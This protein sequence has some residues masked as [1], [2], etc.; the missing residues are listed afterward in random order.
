MKHLLEEVLC[1]CG[2]KITGRALALMG[3][4]CPM[5]GLDLWEAAHLKPK[6]KEE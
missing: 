3:W 5:C 2:V 1:P 6:K 4:K